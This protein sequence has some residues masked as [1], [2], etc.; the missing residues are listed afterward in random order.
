MLQ[1]GRHPALARG[2]GQQPPLQAYICIFFFFSFDGD[3][4]VPFSLLPPSCAALQQQGERS[5]SSPGASPI[6]GKPQP[7][8]TKNDCFPWLKKGFSKCLKK[9]NKTPNQASLKQTSPRP[10]GPAPQ[11]S[12]RP[13]SQPHSGS[14]ALGTSQLCITPAPAPQ[15]WD[16]RRLE[17]TYP[18]WVWQ[19]TPPTNCRAPRSNVYVDIYYSMEGWGEWGRTVSFKKPSHTNEDNN[20]AI[21]FKTH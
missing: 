21:H 1:W 19:Q 10:P 12:P 6:C 17:Q 2:R 11:S 8:A 3:T 9:K 16:K 7:G 18:P 15:A 20:L 13:P 14:P 4:C 5:S